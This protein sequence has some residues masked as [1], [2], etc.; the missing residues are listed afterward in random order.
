[1]ANWSKLFPSRWLKPEHITGEQMNAEILYLKEELVGPPDQQALKPVLYLR[2][3]EQPLI[4]NKGNAA[5]CRAAFSDDERKW[6]GQW[7][8]LH[9]RRELIAGT[10]KDVIRIEA[11]VKA[12]PNPDTTEPSEEELPF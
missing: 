5:V 1:M 7:V 4:L 9:R 8:I 10:W 2:G 12:Q 6:S 11:P 3:I